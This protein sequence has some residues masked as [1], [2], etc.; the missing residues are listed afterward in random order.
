MLRPAQSSRNVVVMTE[1]RRDPV[2]GRIVIVAERRAVRPHTIAAA[3]PDREGGEACPFCRGNEA[4]TPPEIARTGAGEPGDHRWEVRVFPNLYPVTEAH[5]VVV[6]SPD[7]ERSFARLSD[8]Q[9]IAVMQVLRDRVHTR[10][11]DGLPYAVAFVNHRR[12]AGASIAHPHAQV[13][14]LDFVPPYVERVGNRQ[15]SV[16]DDLVDRD[17]ACARQHA[18]VVDEHDTITWC[19]FASVVPFQVRVVD[20][21]AGPRFDDAS[22]AAIAAVARTTRRAL[23]RLSDVL[24]DPPY[25]L[26]VH[27]AGRESPAW[28][29]W[30]VD[31][32]PRVSIPAG[33]EQATG[34]LVNTVSPESA[35]SELRA[36]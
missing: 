20:P 22:D 19:P 2:S 16:R 3:R 8:E 34:V 6:L 11:V 30:H 15:A 4:M 31:I 33:F 32:T 14:G 36:S 5:E 25:N 28:P 21:G 23:E 10:L 29:R 35:A 26:V 12:A 13:V 7:H 9:A 18:L 27:T 17:T 1:L 24:D